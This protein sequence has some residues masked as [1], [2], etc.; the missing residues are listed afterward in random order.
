MTVL[1]SLLSSFRRSRT[2]D[3]RARRSEVPSSVSTEALEP[4]LL[5][6]NP[7]PFSSLPG[8]AVNVYLD[9]D[10]Y[11][12]T[13]AEWI[14]RSAA[15]TGN[16][17]TP[18]FS[19]G[20]DPTFSADE[21]TRIEEIY[22]RVAEDF[23]PFNIN[24]TT[25]LP[26]DINNAEDV[27]VSIG[28]DGSWLLN[29]D[30]YAA[31]PDGFSTSTLP[32][33]V[34]VFSD[35]H[36]GLGGDFEYNMASSISQ[37]VAVSM[38]LEVHNGTN[39]I[40][41]EG[42]AD[43]APIL[44]DSIVGSNTNLASPNSVRDIWVEAPG[45]DGST[46][47]DDLAEIVGNPNVQY[48]ADDYGNTQLAATGITI[49]A[50]VELLDGV[51]E[52]NSDVDVF[53][54]SSA[55]TFATIS[56]TTTDLRGAPFNAPTP[57][58]NL[59]PVLTI[60][61]AS[62]AVLRT[63]DGPELSS[64]VSLNLPG[65]TY[66]VEVSGG[67]EYGNLGAYTLSLGGVGALPSFAN[68]LSLNS[69]PAGNV[70]LY[71]SFAGGLVSG[72]SPFLNG[73]VAGRG[74]Y[75]L[76][77][78]DTDGD[79]ENYS[80]TELAEIEEIW[81]RV[82]EDFRPFNVNV[83][84][85][86]P[87]N[88]D[89]GAAMQV[90]IGGDGA[91][92]GGPDYFALTGAYSDG[93]EPNTA[94][95]FPGVYETS[96]VSDARNTAW[97]A[98]SA[99]AQMLGLDNHAE[100]NAGGTQLSGRDP[101]N[102]QTGPILGQP[103]NSLRDIWVNAA[104]T[105][106]SSTFQDDLAAIVSAA[107]IN[108][109][110]DDVGDLQSSARPIT[111]R[112]GD[113]I[114]TGVIER[115]NDVDVWRFDTL[116]TTATIKVEGLNLI[117]FNP[118][119]SNPGSN[120]DPVLELFDGAGNLIAL[121]DE[122]FAAGDPTALTAS[123]T[124][125]LIAGT[126]F[127]RISNRLEYG[128][129]GEY[130]VTIQ[131]VDSN[132]VTVNINPDSFSENDG[133]QTGIGTVSR[134][135]GELFGSPITVWLQSLDETE[136][137]V[138][139]SVVIPASE[140]SVNFDVTIVDDTLLDG[141]QLVAIQALIPNQAFL[142]R[143]DPAHL[144]MANLNASDFITVRDYE[145]IT[146]T[147]DP[148]PVA[149]NAGFADLTVTRSNTDTGAPN[150]YVVTDNSQLLEFTPTG[151]QV[152]T[153]QIPW[154]SGPVRPGGESVHD[155]EML[156]DGRVVVFNG[157]TSVALSIYNVNSQTWQHVGPF[158]GLSSDPTDPSTG[159]LASTGNFVFMTDLEAFDGDT[160][161]MMRIDLGLLTN[162][163]YNAAQDDFDINSDNGFLSV[164]K[165]F[166]AGTLGSR[167]F[168]IN[169]NFDNNIEEYDPA[170]GEVLQVIDSP[171][172]P[173]SP[174]SYN[175]G[176]IAFDGEFLWA[177]VNSGRSGGPEIIKIDPNT[178]ELLEEHG[179]S[180]LFAPGPDS[181][182]YV[183]G[184]LYITEHD[185]YDFDPD[186]F[187]FE[188]DQFV[189]IYDPV[190]RR[191][192]GRSF[193]P[194]SLNGLNLSGFGSGIQGENRL[195]FLGAIRGTTTR[196]VF[197]LDAT[198]GLV[199]DNTLVS[200]T[201]NSDSFFQVFDP[202]AHLGDVTFGNVTYDDLY[203]VSLSNNVIE[204]YDRTTGNVIDTD[205]S[206]PFLDPLTLGGFFG[207]GRQ[208]TGADVPNVS[209]RKLFF[210]DVTI[211]FDGLL[212]GLEESGDRIS[213][214]KPDT[215][216]RI[217]GID[218][219]TT[220]NTISVGDNSGIYGGGGGGLLTQ[221]D[222]D[223]NV[224]ATLD[225]ALGL[226]TD[227]EVN[228]G[229][230]ILFSD[231]GGVV[232]LTT[233]AD[234]AAQ[235]LAGVT[236]LE[237]TGVNS[238]ISF[239]RHATQS[240]G[241]VLVRLSS[242]DLTELQ[243]P[244]SVVIPRGQQ[245]ITIQVS[246]IDDA[247]RD[248]D[249]DVFVDGTSPEY[250][251]AILTDAGGN[252]LPDVVVTDAEQIG[253]TIDPTEVEETAVVVPDSVTI[254]RTD[255]E[256]P[257]DFVS[258]TAYSNSTSVPIVDKDITISRITVP[259]QVSFLQDVDIKLSLRHDAIPDLDVFLIGPDG[260]RVELFT[261]LSSNESNMTNTILDDEAGIRIVEGVA[262]Y[263]GRFRPEESLENF[264]GINPS[265]IWTLEIID[266]S[267]SD[268]GVL[269][270]WELDLTTI[271]LAE[272][273]VTLSITNS[274]EASVPLVVT[275]PANQAFVTLPLD[276]FD[277][278]IVDGTQT[279]TMTVVSSTDESGFQL[280]G[281]SVDVLD[282]ES[283][284]V[285][286]SQNTV[287]ENAG[288]AAITGTITRLDDSG[289]LTVNLTSSDTSELMVS[290]SV[291]FPD[292]DT[293]VSFSIDVIDDAIFDGDQMVTIL[294]QAPGYSD[295]PTEVITVT[296]EEPRLKLSTIDP[297]LSEADGIALFTIA[298]LDVEDLG[299]PL[300]VALTSSD[301]SELTVPAT[302]TIPAGEI[303]TTFEAIVVDDDLVDGTQPVIITA[304]DAGV[305]IPVVNSTTLDVVVEDAESVNLLVN[306]P[307]SFL[308]NAGDAATTVTVSVTSTG[309]TEPIVVTLTNSDDSELSIPATVTIPVGQSSVS[310]DVDAV[311]DGVLDGDQLVSISGVAVNHQ[312]GSVQIT[313]EDHEP[314][315]LIGPS[316]DVVDPTPELL[317]QS[318]AGATRYDLWVN[319][320]SR[321]IVQLFR[322]EDLPAAHPDGNGV[323]SFIPTQELGVGIYR[324]WVRAYDSLEQ[325]AA[326][327][328][329]RTF[330]IRT[331]PVIT[332]PASGTGVATTTFPDINWTSVVDTDR[333]DLWMNNVT[334]GE[335]QVVRVD[336]LQT[337]NFATAT[338]GLSGGTY[339]VWVRA[340]APDGVTGFWSDSIQFSVLSTP[341]IIAPGGSTFDRTPEVRWNA[342]EG[343]A[344]YDVWLSRQTAGE[345]PA[346]VLRDQ[347]VEGTS[348][349]PKMDLDNGVYAVWVRAIAVDGS[350]TAWSQVQQFEIAGRPVI[351]TPLDNTTSTEPP[352]VSWAG[353]NQAERYEIWVSNSQNERVYYDSEVTANSV[354]LPD[355]IGFGTFRVWVR[356]ISD[357]G[358]LSFWSSPV[359]FTVVSIDQIS[360]EDL[361]NPD[362]L[363]TGFR[364]LVDS[365]GAT[366]PRQV[367]L[368]A[369][370]VQ[371]V[372]VVDAQTVSVR[373]ASTNPSRQLSATETA[374]AESAAGELL[375]VDDVM[376]DW[377][378]AV[379]TLEE[380][381]QS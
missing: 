102:P 352:V 305:G 4:R 311:N 84:T 25:I 329:A 78:Y 175:I 53:S 299:Q 39:G 147:V 96:T 36:L 70:D 49:G 318:L 151:Q 245:S 156:E 225:T 285:S 164:V 362:T 13:N 128:N 295:L 279:V 283:L 196:Q 44:G 193:F 374:A 139:Q 314:P 1:K 345:P 217:R 182:A 287:Q 214:H 92:L 179:L 37:A 133:V 169:S 15:G 381:L 106:D 170:T 266:D 166:G 274:D 288:P 72:S 271:G 161:G 110:V 85:V 64:T 370:E 226:V 141:D 31:I 223:G 21:R 191:L 143:N 185:N 80:A 250:F 212:Y 121:D 8:A 130:T 351:T 88:L 201:V 359:T 98:S 43:V 52:Q 65:G 111:I 194:E 347:F 222:N 153:V 19:I 227:I 23:R 119:I 239:G 109:R 50:G 55:A 376:A 200:G 93:A 379:L 262:P 17:V 241:D 149:E 190:A 163:A 140:A 94:S 152:S 107:N 354:A 272:M 205:P 356:A 60:R 46:V 101:G 136:V 335:S 326:W 2:A 219:G 309:H 267:A 33:S 259:Q 118:L 336:D 342:V 240:T 258:T 124:E 42:D 221:F 348:T 350:A 131:G 273:Q 331:A 189:E 38:G 158:V 123:V 167:L 129:L 99:F 183:D 280:V 173:G 254:Y 213:V 178:G 203:Y 316:L 206:T 112:T 322:L 215:L 187:D 154:H 89:D 56:V 90:V 9:F 344:F 341:Q 290:S 233:Q 296:D 289:P 27:F 270:D 105:Q 291:T 286:L 61:D 40:P 192:T 261:D 380:S 171:T 5:L 372:N 142:D 48:R 66:F 220:V 26:A 81:A 16:I 277:D 365:V 172:I 160:H 34:F 76:S 375:S 202:M 327:S 177:L 162:P 338:A 243:V 144:A 74:D 265:G 369:A 337:T 367:E 238:F 366:Q 249:Q 125:P 302:V 255:V 253:V 353:V 197:E 113:D 122:P 269:L 176:S 28:G 232:A 114:V 24:V 293:T 319:D 186:T 317:W 210:R 51:I 115:N 138:P 242:S 371:S 168:G 248:G 312:S 340:I 247:A 181:I 278:D 87:L 231:A 159:G 229:R 357:R 360:S 108:Y 294:L 260:T 67:G 308:E 82:A 358:E 315:I 377:D 208:F 20:S 330:R 83:T 134:P 328:A 361:L 116:E 211:G 79:F 304:A 3:R 310:F 343:A 58:S 292:G 339:K 236:T 237:D 12:E 368:P 59:D 75:A 155:V 117:D 306:G 275:I 69:H 132:P 198:D 148:N 276:V 313:V 54:F 268:A 100:Y 320:V 235:N 150:H 284:T 63:E 180:G 378:V 165:G 22:E 230:E 349:S 29:P 62:G 35:R 11:T 174:F 10:G 127:I 207:A 355:D 6:T 68:P 32:Q 228:V 300:T 126:Y 97:R 251:Q 77:P 137:I 303:S 363:L 263:T 224:L 282:V 333:Y 252:R 301:L 145:E 373:H 184:L 209:S 204:V 135:A 218:L 325:P 321:D 298:R 332:S 104:D 71:L 146:V 244:D 157:T 307:T 281:D 57:G 95:V 14:T 103:E 45:A 47:Q 324:F 264:D 41:I 86:R 30:R 297:V 256:G 195:A 234:L 323:E 73:R 199:Q 7:D 91:I 334:T 120:L 18:V 216:Q 246:V 346:V 257:L 364:V 188:N